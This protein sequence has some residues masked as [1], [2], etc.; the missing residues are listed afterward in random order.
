MS[1]EPVGEAPAEQYRL[2]VESIPH[3][4]WVARPDGATEYW[5]GRYREYTGA[6]LPEVLGSGWQRVIHPDDLPPTLRAW[7]HSLRTGEP[8][9]IEQRI[10]RADGAYRWHGT[11]AVP[12]RDERGR[13]ARR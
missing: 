12:L 2:M 11:R 9:Y 1:Q 6:S 10:R 13:I 5:N 8:C 3:L 4:V 7:N